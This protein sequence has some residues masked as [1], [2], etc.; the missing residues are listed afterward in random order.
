MRDIRMRGFQILPPVIKN[1]VILNALIFFAQ[2]IF[3]NSETISLDNLFALHD[4]HSKFFKPHQV[5]TYMFMHGT[6]EHIF[7]NM[8]AL[9]M[10]GT[11]LENV[12]GAKRFLI[13]YIVCGIGAGLLH[14]GVLYLEFQPLVNELSMYDV[15]SQEKI[16]NVIDYSTTVGASGSVFGCLAA[17][18]Y[19]FPNNVLMIYFLFPIKAKWFV[20]LYAAAELWAGVANSAGDNVAHWAHLGGALVGIIM[21]IYWNKTNRKQFY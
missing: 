4:V 11:E 1:L 21:V 6:I 19:L 18:G 8:F 10:F 3:K 13:F 9:W 16:R 5:I 14:L 15:A 12:W 2:Y 7:F 20:I 17:F